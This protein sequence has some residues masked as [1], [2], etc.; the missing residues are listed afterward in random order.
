[1]LQHELLPCVYWSVDI[2]TDGD[3]CQYQMRSVNKPYKSEQQQHSNNILFCILICHGT[4]EN[5]N[6]NKNKE[7]DNKD[8][9][10]Y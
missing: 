9:P 4:I 8:K 7:K 2:G 1:M 3:S 5:N 6:K 10:F